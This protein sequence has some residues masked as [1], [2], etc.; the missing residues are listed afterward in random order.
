MFKLIKNVRMVEF[1]YD[2]AK[3][4]G[5]QGVI[6]IGKLPAGTI[7]LGSSTRIIENVV[8]PTSVGDPSVLQIGYGDDAIALVNSTGIDSGDFDAPYSHEGV[9]ATAVTLVADTAVFVTVAVSDL[10]SGKFVVRLGI[11]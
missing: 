11:L 9:V 3:N 5:A 4:G 10:T 2:V 6:E 8:T 1:V 7:L